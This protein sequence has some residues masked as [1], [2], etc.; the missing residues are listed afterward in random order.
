MTYIPLNPKDGTTNSTV[1][2]ISQMG[3]KSLLIGRTLQGTSDPSLGKIIA[4]TDTGDIKFK[5]PLGDIIVDKQLSVVDIGILTANGDIIFARVGDYYLACAPASKRTQKKWGLSGIDT[6][7]HNYSVHYG[8]DFVTPSGYD[9]SLVLDE[10]GS[11]AEA[12]K[13]CRDQTGASY[14]LPNREELILLWMNRDLI[15]SVDNSGGTYKLR[16]IANN[17]AGP[18]GTNNYCLSSTEF[19]SDKV[20]NVR[21][22]SGRFD[23]YSKNTTLSWVCPCTRILA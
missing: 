21:M 14:F 22:S 4:R 9:N 11:S 1:D 5:T 19:D 10:Y 17:G 15:D 7:L 13:W 8:F 2:P 16:Y 23:E 18:S 3:S 20:W 12:N 6:S